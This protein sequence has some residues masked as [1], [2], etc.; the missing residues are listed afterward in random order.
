[1]VRGRSEKHSL[2]E[3]IEVKSACNS[4]GLSGRK[5][6]YSVVQRGLE[7]RY[8]LQREAWW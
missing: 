8:T 6:V 4:D 5:G 3:L 7:E 2:G 1:M